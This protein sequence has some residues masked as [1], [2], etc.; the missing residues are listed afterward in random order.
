MRHVPHYKTEADLCRAFADAATAAGWTVYNET[1]GWDQLLVNAGGEQIG[2]QA[3]LRA[4]VAVLCQA[5]KEHRAGPH[6]R[7]P[8]VGPDYR[9]VL[10]GRPHDGFGDVAR[11]CRLLVVAPHPWLEPPLRFPEL[12]PA[13]HW[14][15]ERRHDVPRYIPDV[16][17]GVPCPIQLTPWKLTAIRLCALLRSRG[18][19][20][21]A[22]FKREGVDPRR[23]FVGS[24]PWLLKTEGGIYVAG[25][26]RLPDED[27]PVVAAAVAKEM[28]AVKEAV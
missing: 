3:K 10:V 12:D 27:H 20:T 24:E 1:A 11:A 16:P 14:H 26:G 21:P 2:V 8:V 15:P 23:W 7:Q 4:N 6:Y 17:A 28:E 18:H 22:D 5:M 19:L 13:L 25:S 9:L